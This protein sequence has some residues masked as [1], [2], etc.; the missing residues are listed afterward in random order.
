M[1]IATVT[2]GKAWTIPSQTTAGV[3]YQVRMVN[4]ALTCDCDGFFFRGTCKHAAAVDTTYPAPVASK[5][6]PEARSWGLSALT[7]GRQS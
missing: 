7:G 3:M 1:T 5:L 4:G 2:N 6:S